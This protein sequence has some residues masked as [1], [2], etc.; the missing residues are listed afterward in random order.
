MNKEL[1]SVLNNNRKNIKQISMDYVL[2]N[3]GAINDLIDLSLG[4]GQPQGWRAAWVLAE[5]VKQDRNLLKLIQPYSTKIIDLFPS[6][7][8]PGQ[9]RE[10]LKIVQ[11]LDLTD[12]EMGLLLD[13]C[14]KWLLDKK[15]DESFKIYSME[16]I[17]EFSK[18]EPDILPELIAIIEQEMVYAKPGFK[19]RGK[20]ILKYTQKI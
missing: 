4:N 8:S 6:F 18:K 2:A 7:N 13:L 20:K 17:F 11:L 5:L 16:I 12:D 15:S 19:C 14:Y 3:P 10:F 1:I 9:I